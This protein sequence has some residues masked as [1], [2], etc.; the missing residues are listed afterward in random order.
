MLT[1]QA[2][3]PFSRPRSGSRHRLAMAAVVMGMLVVLF[4]TGCYGAK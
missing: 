1:R 2:A 3:R 4:A